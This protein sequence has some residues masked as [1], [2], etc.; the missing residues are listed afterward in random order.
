MGGG[1][2]GNGRM[3]R[4]HNLSLTN[5][6]FPGVS[7]VTPELEAQFGVRREGDPGGSVWSAVFCVV[8]IFPCGPRFANT[9]IRVLSLTFRPQSSLWR[10]CPT[11]R[12]SPLASFSP[13]CPYLAAVRFLG[14]LLLTLFSQVHFNF[15]FRKGSTRS[16][17][18][19][20]SKSRGGAC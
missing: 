16:I 18:L 14:S 2:R 17:S 15:S 8:R 5:S 4:V 19:M 6:R 9:C 10:C 13:P 3:D 12:F 7:Q 11:L 1:G 20:F